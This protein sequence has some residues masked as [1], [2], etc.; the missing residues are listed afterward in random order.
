MRNSTSISPDLR[1]SY[2]SKKSVGKAF[3]FLSICSILLLVV[4]SV[5]YLWKMIFF[6][7][8]GEIDSPVH[9][10]ARQRFLFPYNSSFGFPSGWGFLRF[11][12]PGPPSPK[13]SSRGFPGS[14]TAFR[15]ADSVQQCYLRQKIIVDG[16]FANFWPPAPFSTTQTANSNDHLIRSASIE[17][18][19]KPY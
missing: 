9:P 2:S 4:S 10:N 12:S 11:G 8:S 14:K 1:L 16:F 17:N 3:V 13:D 5:K 6:D 7:K 19:E 18:L 15:A